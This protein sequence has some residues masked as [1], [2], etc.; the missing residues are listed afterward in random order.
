MYLK[1]IT[2][3]CVLHILFSMPHITYANSLQ[4]TLTDSIKLALAH[5]PKLKFAEA[6]LA[7]KSWQIKENQAAY[8]PTL[9]VSHQQSRNHQEREDASLNSHN[10]V[11]EAKTTLYSGGLNEGLVAQAKELHAGAQYNFIYIKQQVITNTYLAYYNLLQSEKNVALAEESVQRLTQHLSVVQAQYQEGT[12]IKSDVLRTEVELAQAKQNYSRARNN[13]QLANNQF[14]TLL[15][16]PSEQSITLAESNDTPKYDGS[17][18]QAVQIALLQRT[19]LKQIQQDE[20][21]TQYGIKIAKSGYMPT[22]SLSIK[23]EWP[24]QE[25]IDNSWSTQL[26]VDFNV[27]DGNKTKSKIKQ[28]EW[29]NAKAHEQ[30]QE[31]KEQI[32]LETKEAYFNLQNSQTALDIASQVVVKAEEDYTITLVRY[33]SGIG[34]NLDVIDSQGALTSAKLNYINASYDYNKYNVQLAQAMG[35]ITE[36]DSNGKK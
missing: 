29:E 15:G 20:K 18:E 35:I 14:L 10:T 27:F 36:E 28:A 13:S 26:S 31:K 5:S 22:V 19:D 3:I 17:L 34:S 23:K 30:L 4:L 16:L 32:T 21:V 7:K 6:E 11:L 24:N 12:V 2:I 8:I 9:N 25:N 33:Q 1:K